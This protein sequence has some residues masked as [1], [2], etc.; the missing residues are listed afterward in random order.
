MLILVGGGARSGKSKY[1]LNLAQEFNS[2]TQKRVLFLATAQASDEEMK[3]RIARHQKERANYFDLIEEATDIAGVLASK[4][5]DQLAIVDCL[6]IWLSNLMYQETEIDFKKVLASARTRSADT[7][8]VTN[9]VG[10]GIV[11]M[12]P[13]SREFRDLSGTM[14]QIF[15][16]E[17]DR[18]IFMKFG[19]EIQLK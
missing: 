3:E 9:E 5:P 11:P 16:K 8:F 6:T 13:V 2:E 14:N 10:E 7:I 18:V 1:A 12:H 17:C 4:N 19:L 15:A